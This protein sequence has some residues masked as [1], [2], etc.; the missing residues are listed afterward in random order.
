MR[1]KRN[2]FAENKKKSWHE[3]LGIKICHARIED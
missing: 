3:K 2:I 1:V